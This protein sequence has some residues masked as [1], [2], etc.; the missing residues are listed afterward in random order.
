MDSHT[1][2]AQFGRLEVVETGRRRRWSED[3][4]LRIVMESLRGRRLVSATARRYGIT[5]SMLV[6]W[7]RAFGPEQ[8]GPKGAAPGFVPAVIVPEGG[9]RTGTAPTGTPRDTTGK[10]PVSFVP[11]VVA[12]AADQEPGARP[13]PRTGAGGS[14]SRSSSLPPS[15]GARPPNSPPADQPLMPWRESSPRHGISS[16]RTGESLASHRAG[17]LV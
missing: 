7:R 12:A 10:E 14:G 4:K 9:P 11:A 1:H 2:S 17:P 3:E 6:T 15:D 13:E 5:R 16:N 8:V